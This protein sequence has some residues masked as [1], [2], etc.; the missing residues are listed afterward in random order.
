MNNEKI[1]KIMFML[2]CATVVFLYGVVVGKYHVF[3]Y[4]MLNY[5]H[6]TI[7]DF[8]SE[9][10]MAFGLRPREFLHPARHDGEGV[11][12]NMTGKAAPGLTLISG[13]FDN[14]VEM[15]LIRLD[16]SI[17]QRWPVRFS[18][19]WPEPVHIRPQELVPKTDWNT[20]VHGALV[21]PDG[22]VIFNLEYHGMVKLDRCGNLE[23]KLDR[24]THHSLEPASDGGFWVGGRRYVE[25]R[26]AFPPLTV[27][28]HEDLILKVSEDGVV[29]KELSVPALLYESDLRG[30]L[31]ANGHDRIEVAER[32]IVHLNDIEELTPVA[33]ADFPM[34]AAGDLL[35]SLRELNLVFVVDP[36]KRKIKW[37]QVGPWLRQHD[38]DFLPGGTIS[39]FNNNSDNT[40]NGSVFGGSN[41]VEVSPESGRTTRMYG[42]ASFFTSL[43][44][45]HQILPNGNALITEFAR[46]RVFEVDRT[47][48][49]VWEFINRYDDDE[50]AEVTQ[51]TRYPET[52]FTVDRWACE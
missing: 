16:G 28:Y 21:Q 25:T 50:V 48:A 8:R 30:L 40:D 42:N 39:V 14:G 38:P 15:R 6:D 29:T 34:F 18:A 37:H 17:V 10:A 44:G 26:S 35:L 20:D 11:T 49:V 2:S 13:F 36:D 41:V 5:V 1:P 9:A 23:W 51:A 12:V 7:T 47:G 24:M 52:Y 45:K 43:R 33:A 19:I 31:F 22:S 46:G 27:P 3:P 32:E 4:H